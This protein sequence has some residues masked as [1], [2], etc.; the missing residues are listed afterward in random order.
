MTSIIIKHVAA[1]LM[2]FYGHTQNLAPPPVKDP[3]APIKKDPIVQDSSSMFS[4][5]FR[6][7]FDQLNN[8]PLDSLKVASFAQLARDA[9]QLQDTSLFY[10]I[11]SRAMV[12]AKKL[13][14]PYLMADIHWNWGEYHL[15]RFRY[16]EAYVN[17]REAEQLFEKSN[18]TYYRAKMFY[19]MG[20]IESLVADY[21]RAEM[22]LFMALSF[23]KDLNKEPQIMGVYNLLGSV[24][25][26]MEDYAQAISYYKAALD[27]AARG[28]PII[29]IPIS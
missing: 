28:P 4:A 11:N 3:F 23:F 20:Y 8:L 19:N 5:G 2:V 26:G 25:D 15:S 9:I 6:Q 22:N 7:S 21:S 10:I 1:L 14:H 18:H 17:Y 29:F 16:P 24:Y 27:L 12:L 13:D